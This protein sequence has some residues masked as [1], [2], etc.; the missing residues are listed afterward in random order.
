MTRIWKIYD[1]PFKGV[2]AATMSF[3][4]YPGKEIR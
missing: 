3:S 1:F 2:A 4:S